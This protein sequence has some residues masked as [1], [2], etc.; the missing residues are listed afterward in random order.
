MELAARLLT[1][2][3]RLP[4]RAHDEDAA[5]DLHADEQ[6]RLAPGQRATV[7]TGVALELPAGVCALVLARSGLAA[8]H[9]IT[10]LNAPG[11][12][13]PGYRGEILVILLNTDARE[14]FTIEPGD[15]IA[16]LALM[17]PEPATLRAVSKQLAGSVRGASGLG[18]SG[19]R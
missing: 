8:R 14:D 11:L 15:R 19:R 4:A 9:G 13:D 18:S 2:T 12:I 5:F 7:S 17:R 1:D 3:A 10:V 16:Q 6:L